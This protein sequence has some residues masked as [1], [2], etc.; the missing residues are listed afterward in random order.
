MRA[1]PRCKK[2]VGLGAKRVL[3]V[4]V[5][6]ERC[7]N[8]YFTPS[9]P[10][11]IPVASQMIGY[12][13]FGRPFR[14][15]TIRFLSKT[16]RR[17][18]TFSALPKTEHAL[19]DK[20]I[21]RI[22]TTRATLGTVRTQGAFFHRPGHPVKPERFQRHSGQQKNGRLQKNIRMGESHAD[23]LFNSP[24]ETDGCLSGNQANILAVC[25]NT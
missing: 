2:P 15:T 14:H 9:V 1:P 21:H 5:K 18:S 25:R 24:S 19:F 16:P 6:K 23:V 12:S 10:A 17:T 11:L 13:G 3:T 4:M 8:D 20:H 7:Q 22:R